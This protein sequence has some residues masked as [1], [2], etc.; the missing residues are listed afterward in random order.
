M[1]KI[2]ISQIESFKD[3]VPSILCITLIA[4]SWLSFPPF[5][6]WLAINKNL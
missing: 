1:L 2:D 4:A 5:D 6:A 3:F